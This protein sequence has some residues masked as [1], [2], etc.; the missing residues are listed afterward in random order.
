[1]AQQILQQGQ[2]FTDPAGRT[3]IV[4]FNT[5]TG[6]KLNPGEFTV[7]LPDNLNS[8]N[9]NQ[10][11]TGTDITT[12]N[13]SNTDATSSFS[14]MIG[15]ITDA[16]KTASADQ[17]KADAEIKALQTEKTQQK[18][19]IQKIIEKLAGTSKEQ[20]QLYQDTGVD[21]AKK[22]VDEI[23]NQIE[24]EQ[25]ANRRQIENI[26]KNFHGSPEGAAAVIRAATSESLSRQADLAIIQNATLRRYDTMKSIADRQIA[27]E[28]DYLKTELDGLK[29]FYQD[30]KDQ[31]TKAEDRQW[32]ETIKA[33]D[34]A[35]Q[36]K[37][38]D[39]TDIKNIKIEAAKN[40][41]SLDTLTN[42]GNAKT[43]DEALRA[44]GN[45]LASSA[46]EFVKLSD[47]STALVN[48]MTGKVIKNLGGG[49]ETTPVDTVIVRTVKT[50]D[51]KNVAVDGYNLISGD[52]PYLIAQKYGLDMAGLQR[53]NPTITDWNNLPV[54]ATINV[55]SKTAGTG[56]ILAA[57]GLSKLEFD[58]LT[59]GTSALTR[60]SEKT[61]QEVRD[62]VT[63]WANKNNI[64][65]ST[66]QSQYKAIGNTVE[67]NVLRNNQA[68]VTENELLGTIS[69]IRQAANEANLGDLS[70][71]NTA[72]IWAGKQLNSPEATTFLFHLEQIRKEYATYNAVLGGGIDQNGNV[73]ELN[74]SDYAAADKIIQN[75]FARGSIDGFEN[76][77]KRS[78]EKMKGVLENSI[79]AQNKQVWNLF[80]VGD[81]YEMK[82]QKI[83]PLTNIQNYGNAHPDQQAKL[84]QMKLDGVSIE[85]I[86]NWVNQQSQ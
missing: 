30:N 59:Q 54:G 55:P 35:Y 39:L 76:A 10:I 74:P 62:K 37:L 6:A 81:Q 23:T 42:I 32:Q 16:N 77:L 12:P 48:K 3:G 8:A 57:T 50:P 69:N 67:A 85:D 71:L 9:A 56:S 51:G 29:F 22:A 45:S 82:T 5:Q 14:D 18:S 34:R 24:A 19:S 25:L 60:L 4:N 86:S 11:G 49:G 36:E 15:S 58:Y 41:A 2:S 1:M 44:A 52:D 65:V 33:K 20:D 61:R 7:T 43:F 38:Q 83:D 75:G 21:N 26:Q 73:R 64:D 27:A 40:G 79:Q 53:L 46:N 70:K 78:T 13:L 31:L 17:A 47:G 28:T 72:K 68:T 80:G 84:T 66:F 63:N